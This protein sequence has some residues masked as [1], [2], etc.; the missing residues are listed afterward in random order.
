MSQFER[1]YC[2]SAAWRLASSAI[3]R[4]LRAQRL[5]HDILEI[6]AGSGS[7]AQQILS[8]DPELAWVAIDIDPHMTIRSTPSSVV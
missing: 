2:C 7:V 5:G 4:A 8:K 6:G 1:A 3:A